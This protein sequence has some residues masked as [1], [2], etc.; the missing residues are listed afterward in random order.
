MT[1]RTHASFRVGCGPIRRARESGDALSSFDVVGRSRTRLHH[2]ARAE[3]RIAVPE[4]SAAERL[5]REASSPP[6]SFQPIGVTCLVRRKAAFD[7]ALAVEVAEG[8]EG[9]DAGLDRAAC[10]FTAP[11]LSTGDMSAERQDCQRSVQIRPSQTYVSFSARAIFT[12]ALRCRFVHTGPWSPSVRRACEWGPSET[13]RHRRP[14]RAGRD[15]RRS[16]G[17]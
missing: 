14:R 3:L 13:H 4:P 8:A 16:A 11:M 6:P 10:Y 1:Q 9:E 7:D 5:A 15:C 2:V 17:R 12:R